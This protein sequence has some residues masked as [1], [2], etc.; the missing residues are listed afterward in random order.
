IDRGR[1]TSRPV[2][3]VSWSQRAPRFR[4]TSPQRTVPGGFDRNRGRHTENSTTLSE[5]TGNAPTG[6]GH[7]SARVASEGCK[8][9]RWTRVSRSS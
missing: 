3:H 4:G 7:T 5:T 6:T 2:S 1:P 9:T 8:L